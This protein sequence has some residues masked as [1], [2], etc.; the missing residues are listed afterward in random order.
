MWSHRRSEEPSPTDTF[1]TGKNPFSPA[2]RFI[3]TAS[4]VKILMVT[5]EVPCISL[6]RPKLEAAETKIAKRLKNTLEDIDILRKRN[7]ELHKLLENHKID[8][9]QVLKNFQYHQADEVVRNDN[10]G[11]VVQKEVLNAENETPASVTIPELLPSLQNIL[12]LVAQHTKWLLRNM[13]KLAEADGYATWRKREVSKLSNLVQ[14]R[15]YQLQNP[16]DCRNAKQIVCDLNVHHSFGIQLH[17]IVFCFIVAY[18]T[19]R[20]LILK[21]DNWYYGQGR[22]NDVFKP[23]SNTCIDFNE[24]DFYDFYTQ[25]VNLPVVIDFISPTSSYLRLAIPEDLAPRLVRLHDN[26]VVWWIEQILKYVY[27]PNEKTAAFLQN[28]SANLGFKRP[29]VGVH[30]RRTDKIGKRRIYLATDN[31]EVITKARNEYPHYEILDDSTIAKTASAV[32]RCFLT[33][34][35]GII[36]DLHMLSMSDFLVC[37][38]SSRVCRLAYE[39]MQNYFP[40]ASAKVKLLDD[41]Y[42]FASQSI[43]FCT[44]IMAHDS[45]RFGEIQLLPGDLVSIDGNHWNG[46]SK[47]RNMRTNQTGLFPSFKHHHRDSP[48]SLKF[49]FI[50]GAQLQYPRASVHSQQPPR[51]QP[52]F[53]PSSPTQELPLSSTCHT[54]SVQHYHQPLSPNNE[55]RVRQ[56]GPSGQRGRTR[57]ANPNPWK[58]PPPTR[59][60]PASDTHKRHYS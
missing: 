16:P 7:L 12:D 26:P 5:T 4:F 28:A 43:N 55:R 46:Y 42:Y 32:N 34:L 14:R 57:A 56:T 8:Q 44:A 47:E 11:Y 9:E 53:T 50:I 30:V 52:D 33:A 20:T 35:K 2:V 21:S 23:I 18:R 25:I 31:P 3:A 40:D 6:K 22:W 15:F 24:N 60:P 59:Q 45:N 58:S 17:R 29:I 39:I 37:T 54:P 41:I 10:V 49:D 13:D 1:A 27:R 51:H 38:F 36:F 19:Q 48:P